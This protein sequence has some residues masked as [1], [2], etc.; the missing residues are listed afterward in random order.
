MGKW[1][2]RMRTDTNLN[3]NTETDS[4]TNTETDTN[5]NPETDTNSRIGLRSSPTLGEID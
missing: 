2:S 3:A 5:S 1:K 4:N